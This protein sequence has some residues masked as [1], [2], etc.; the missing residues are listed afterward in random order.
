M[1][2]ELR[3]VEKPEEVKTESWMKENF[4]I[5]KH[6]LLVQDLMPCEEHSNACKSAARMGRSVGKATG[7]V[8]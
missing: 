1:L 4:L 8:E 5:Q 3:R 2:V 7:H 6:F